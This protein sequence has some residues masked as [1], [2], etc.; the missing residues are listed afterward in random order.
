LN[1][2]GYETVTLWVFKDNAAARGLYASEGFVPDGGA[3][4]EAQFRTDE[5]SMRRE[6]TDAG[7]PDSSVGEVVG[8]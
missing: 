1:R 8:A 4:V 5:I 6:A 3:R 2:S 7:R